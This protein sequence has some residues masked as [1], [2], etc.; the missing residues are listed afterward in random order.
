MKSKFDING[1]VDCRCGDQILSNSGKVC[2]VANKKGHVSKL[3]KCWNP[4][5][6][7]VYHGDDIYNV[8]VEGKVVVFDDSTD[9]K[10]FRVGDD[11]FDWV[12]AKSQQEAMD[13]FNENYDG[14]DYELDDYIE[15]SLYGIIYEEDDPGSQ[16]TIRKTIEQTPIENFPCIIASTEF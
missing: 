12:A 15:C 11:P 14:E 3:M 4:N 16:V 1:R 5:C 8:R 13:Y 6:E 7:G 9:M 2:F 10:V